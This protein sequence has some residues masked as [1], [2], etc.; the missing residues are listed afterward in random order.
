[1][2]NL[3][4]DQKSA[5]KALLYEYRDIASYSQEKLGIPQWNKNV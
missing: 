2:T 4:Q 3:N 1:M 5:V